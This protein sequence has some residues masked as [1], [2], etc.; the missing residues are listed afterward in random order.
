MEAPA[1][2]SMALTFALSFTVV[3][4][5]VILPLASAVALNDWTFALFAPPAVAKMSKL[6]ST[7]WP[8]M[9]TLKR[10]WPAEFP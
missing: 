9:L 3:K 1:T 6:L 2:T 8:L 5:I 10:R 7:C 4:A